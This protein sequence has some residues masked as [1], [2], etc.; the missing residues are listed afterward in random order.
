MKEKH[1]LADPIDFKRIIGYEPLYASMC[2]NLDEIE[3]FTI[4]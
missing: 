1:Y 3:I 4:K 2:N